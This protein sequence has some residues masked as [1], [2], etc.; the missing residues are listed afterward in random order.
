MGLFIFF[1]HDRMQEREK[2]QTERK[3]VGG[4]QGEEV[5]NETDI[6]ERRQQ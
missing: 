6:T 5:S 2:R 1:E 3:T 4:G